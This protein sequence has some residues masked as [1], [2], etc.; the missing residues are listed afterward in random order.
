[1]N[2]VTIPNPLPANLLVLSAETMA[3]IATLESQAAAIVDIASPEDMAAAD[4]VVEA[5][6][7]LDKAIEAERKRLKAPILELSNALD[8]AAGEARAPLLAIK[9]TVGAKVQAFIAIENRRREEERRRLEEQRRAAEEAARIAAEEE[10]R[11]VEAERAAANPA[12]WDEPAVALAP[13]EEPAAPVAPAVLP[14]TYEEQM[15]AAPLKSAAVCVRTTKRVEVTDPSLVP[16]EINGVRLWVLDLKA[17]EKLAK[18]GLSIPGVT[19]TE[20]ETIAAK[21]R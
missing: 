6:I 16:D 11:R 10:R 1:M 9:Q 12:P 8:N 18:A 5:S 13:W 2:A 7:K 20:V 17:I 21:G 3:R 4:R 14:P 19:V 15:A